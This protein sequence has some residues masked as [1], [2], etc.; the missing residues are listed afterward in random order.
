MQFGPGE[1]PM[2]AAFTQPPIVSSSLSFIRTIETWLSKRGHPSRHLSFCNSPH[3]VR[4]L[5]SMEKRE[6]LSERPYV[7]PA[8]KRA[9]VRSVWFG[10]LS[11]P[12]SVSEPCVSS[13]GRARRRHVTPGVGGNPPH[14]SWPAGVVTASGSDHRLKGR[15]GDGVILVL[16]SRDKRSSRC[17]S[18]RIVARQAVR[19]RATV[20]SRRCQCLADG[21]WKRPGSIRTLP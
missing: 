15:G 1:K 10:S 13:P 17:F 3:P 4:T 5:P 21:E 14:R 8:L 9:P 16:S 18:T 7:V 12:V 2:H 11:H 20:F 6:N 19:H